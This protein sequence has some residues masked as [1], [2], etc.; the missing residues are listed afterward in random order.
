M[1]WPPL[2]HV[3]TDVCIFMAAHKAGSIPCRRNPSS[4]AMGSFRVLEQ[5]TANELPVN[6]SIHAYDS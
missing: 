6:A 2:G 4:A 5:S 1:L 3:L